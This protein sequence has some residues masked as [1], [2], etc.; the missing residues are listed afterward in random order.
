MSITRRLAAS[1]CFLFFLQTAA[2]QEGIHWPQF[3]GLIY[4]TTRHFETDALT[5]FH[6]LLR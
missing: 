1:I 6:T 4:P 3:R 2:A 5:P